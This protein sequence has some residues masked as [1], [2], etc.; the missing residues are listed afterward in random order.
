MKTRSRQLKV[1]FLSIAL[2]FGACK[3]DDNS[4][5]SGNSTNV[6]A[7][8]TSGSWRVSYFSESGDDYTADF[9]GYVFV[10]ATGGQLTATK[11][12]VTTNGTWSRD[13]SSNKLRLTIFSSAPHE[14][15]SDDWVVVEN[16]SS[17]IKLNDDNP[18]RTDILHFIRN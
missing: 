13:D 5:S 12:G 14:K 2:F 16:S 9:S 6:S 4:S 1:I 15:I 18:A 7:N 10:F 3:K 8:I 17:M 11:S